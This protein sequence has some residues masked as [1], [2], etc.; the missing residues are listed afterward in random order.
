MPARIRLREETPLLSLEGDLLHVSTDRDHNFRFG[1]R[2]N[3]E[4][5]LIETDPLDMCVGRQHLQVEVT[6]PN[7]YIRPLP[8]KGDT[9]L[10]G[11]SLRGPPSRLAAAEFCT[12]PAR[13]KLKPGDVIWVPGITFTV[14]ALA[15]IR[16]HP[17]PARQPEGVEAAGRPVVLG[18]PPVVACWPGA[19]SGA[20]PLIEGFKYATTLGGRPASGLTYLYKREDGPEVVGEK[21]VVKYFSV[22]ASCALD[23]LEKQ[24]SRLFSLQ[25]AA[26]HHP[27][28]YSLGRIAAEGHLA[29]CFPWLAQHHLGGGTFLDLAAIHDVLGGVLGAL[30]A[31]HEQ[32]LAHGH[33]CAENIF[34][35]PA[36][37]IAVTDGGLNG[38][39]SLIGAE[40]T[41]S[42]PSPRNDLLAL[43][44]LCLKLLGFPPSSPPQAVPGR[45]RD[46]KQ[47]WLGLPLYDLAFLLRE[48]PHLTTIQALEVFRGVPKPKVERPLTA[49]HWRSSRGEPSST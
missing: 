4:V 15:V 31:L 44:D 25:S 19:S 35:A 45:A 20:P 2:S 47:G 23:G 32:G 49:P 37:K 28:A 10:N 22:G 17:S 29:I 1:R 40:M 30:A 13:Q 39:R 46:Q 42:D 41:G 34:L 26:L 6:S 48:N 14:V 27:S 36:G 38:I 9:K 8:A 5:I 33:L 21:W 7:C 18:L 16:P 11:K 3:C 43:G 12:P 24:I